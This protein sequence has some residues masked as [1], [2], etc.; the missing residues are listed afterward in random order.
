MFPHSVD[1]DGYYRCLTRKN[2]RPKACDLRMSDL[3]PISPLTRTT[4]LTI[5]LRCARPRCNHQ[6]ILTD[7]LESYRRQSEYWEWMNTLHVG[8]HKSSKWITLTALARD[9]SPF[10]QSICTRITILKRHRREVLTAT[11]RE[12]VCWIDNYLLNVYGIATLLALRQACK[13]WQRGLTVSRLV[14]TLTQP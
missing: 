11:K 2:V 13:A 7:G 5:T 1:N 4:D 14:E 9:L 10:V 8:N 12:P 6:G 3:K